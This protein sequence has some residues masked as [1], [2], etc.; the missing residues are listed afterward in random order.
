[1]GE[2]SDAFE[3]MMARARLE[4]SRAEKRR[5][6]RP[7]L[8]LVPDALVDAS[9]ETRTREA[10]EPL[11]NEGVNCVELRDKN[12]GVDAVVIPADRYV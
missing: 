4:E 1:M 5:R 11:A 10:L 9:E 2:G 6:L 7:E 8:R 12:L 3:R